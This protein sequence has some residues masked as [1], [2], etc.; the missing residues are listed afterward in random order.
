MQ[1]LIIILIVVL[2]AQTCVVIYA[3]FFDLSRA[4]QYA[5]TQEMMTNTQSSFLAEKSRLQEC[6]DNRDKELARTVKLYNQLYQ[7]YNEIRIRLMNYNKESDPHYCP[8][9]EQIKS[10]YAAI[11][12]ME[13]MNEHT[14]AKNLK[15]LWV[16]LKEWH[17]QNGGEDIK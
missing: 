3:N 6:I 11:G 5:S 12:V 2:I 15:E 16:G 14:D 13:Q 8:T 1:T 7:E 10:V 17:M 4:R 9:I